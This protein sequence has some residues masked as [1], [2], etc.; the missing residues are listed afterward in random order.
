MIFK[1]GRY[2]AYVGKFMFI[3]HAE[4]PVKHKLGLKGRLF[5]DRSGTGDFEVREW[6][7][8]R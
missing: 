4:N 6:P 1:V 3:W 8:D 7:K 2:L 5:C